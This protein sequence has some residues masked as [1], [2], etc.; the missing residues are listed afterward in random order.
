MIF[1][2]YQSGAKV[3]LECRHFVHGRIEHTVD[4]VTGKDGVYKLELKDNHENEIC[5]VV[6]VESPIK[7]CA[8]TVPGRNCARVVLSDDTGISSNVRFANPLGFL[9][10]VPLN[11]CSAIMQMYTLGDDEQM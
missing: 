5:E 3:K 10:D 4:G 2:L 8:Q 1:F 9:K 6:L 11:V 7:D